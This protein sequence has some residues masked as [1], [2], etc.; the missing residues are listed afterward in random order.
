MP[1]DFQY[2][3]DAWEDH[4]KNTPNNVVLSDSLGKSLKRSECEDISARIYAWLRLNK[5]GKEDFVLINLD[6]GVK[7]VLAV[8]GV[9]KNGSAFSLVESGY[10]KERIAYIK[11][12]CHAVIE[13]NE[14]NWD[15]I[16]K[17]SPLSGHDVPDDH[18]SCMTVYTSGTTGTPKGVL[19]EYGQMKLEM[20]SE[21]RHDGSW[22]ENV[23][24][25]WGLV[26]P[27]NFVASLK[28]I[29]HF[30]YCGG[31]LHVLDY[32]TVKNPKKLNAYFIKNR[33]NE[34]F[35]SPSLLRIKGDYF[36]PFMKYI[37][38]GA[39]PANNVF[40]KGAELVNTYTMSESF[41]TV[42]EFIIDK[43]YS[44]VPIGNPM[45]DLKIKLLGEDGKE[46]ATGERGELCYYN[47]Y[48]RGYINNE[49][50]NKKHFI[51]GWFHTGDLAV[52]SDGA[53]VLKGRSDDMIK[54]DGNRIEPSEIEAVCKEE[55]GISNCVA[56]GFEKGFVALYYVDDIEFNEDD[57]RNRLKKSLPYYMIPTYY[58]KIDKFPL[59]Q[60]GKLDRKALKIP[61]Q[62]YKAEYVAPR[63]EFEKSLC[64][65][66][67]QIL[68]VEKIGIKDDF[69]K[70]GGTSID[71]IELLT[72]LDADDDLSPTMLY[73][74]RTIENI[75]ALYKEAKANHI[76]PEEKEYL[77]RQNPCPISEVQSLF[78]NE[79]YDCSLDFHFGMRILPFVS[80][81]MIEERI[82]RYIDANSTFN[83]VVRKDANGNPIQAYVAEKPYVKVEHMSLREAESECDN[84]VQRFTYDEPL[85]RIRLIKTP[86]ASFFLF[87]ASHV[88]MDGA[89][90]HFAIEDMTAAIKGEEI[91]ITNYFAFAYEETQR[92]KK[93]TFEQ[94]LAYFKEKYFTKPRVANLIS[95]EPIPQNV[96][97][98][99]KPFGLPLK[100]L[101]KYC[102]ERNISINVFINTA[103]LLT[104]CAYN[105]SN[106]GLVF[107]N[108]HNRGNGGNRGGVS[109]RS[110]I[111]VMDMSQVK[112]L[113]DAYELIKKQN[114]ED[115][116]RYRDHDF[117]R[118][119]SHLIRGPKMTITY[120]EGWFTDDLPKSLALFCRRYSVR[121]HLKST[122][123]TSSNT[124]M[125]FSHYRG[126]LNCGMQYC[127]ASL[128]TESA[129]RYHNML[130]CAMEDMLEDR[131]PI[132]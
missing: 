20:I 78:W 29:V 79:F 38:T 75:S 42:C 8:M 16:L 36:G 1:I 37:Y 106:D 126:K 120:M 46:V 31:H 54:I 40:V 27:L 24:T 76:T 119:F 32:D 132:F 21:Q 13:I 121:N 105:K 48:C 91:P 28:I 117:Y 124:L 25:K 129:E 51:D 111:N 50:E 122:S 2:C 110:A 64:E 98:H 7:P 52:Y 83:M 86:T 5:V 62:V 109:Y 70:L 33:I 60:S 116:W 56:K 74:G 59:N 72:I 57:L 6:R 17:T 102:E 131:L 127:T 10:A 85:I 95:D 45:F 43:S 47:P 49:E 90:C 100:Q 9:L 80:V 18:D 22:R 107:W 103:V 15:E 89:A 30:L 114:E 88:V 53:Y 65:G 108:Y 34:T 61:K 3:L 92:N 130:K 69:F 73:E 35:L 77:G 96:H 118:P 101:R 44:I 58:I 55:M 12:N 19:H 99:T 63:D 39:E 113:E 66:F 23:D 41:F 26:A 94:N 97:K 87:H 112:S 115:L 67:S 4:T 104:Q 82:N 68:G 128:R 11:E 71:A 123:K 81:K 14:N 125:S 84:F 93:N